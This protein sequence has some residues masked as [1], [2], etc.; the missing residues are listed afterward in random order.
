V[1]QAIAPELRTLE[2]T[3]TIAVRLETVPDRLVEVF[4]AEMPR[5]G[6]VMADIGAQMT[7]APFA[8]YHH[9]G[10]DRVD[11]EIGAPI[12]FVPA[13][14]Q[15]VSGMPDGVIGA[16]SLPG[17]IAAVAVHTGP[18]DTLPDTYDAMSGWM[19]AEGHAAGSGPWEVYLAD[20]GQVSDPADLET[21]VVWP[22]DPAAAP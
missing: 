19:A 3:T 20:P 22:I 15:P 16:S 18:Y 7:G 8:R 11:L 2:P 9:F 17:G 1:T 5:V 21:E 10:S 12:A 13:G 4:A 14:L 6:A